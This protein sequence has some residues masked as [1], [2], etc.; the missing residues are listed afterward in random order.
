MSL[1]REIA[2]VARCVLAFLISLATELRIPYGR[3]LQAS[4]PLRHPITSPSSSTTTSKSLSSVSSV[5]CIAGELRLFKPGTCGRRPLR[6]GGVIEPHDCSVY[7]IPSVGDTAIPVV[8]LKA[9][10]QSG[11][12][13]PQCSC[14]TTRCDSLSCEKHGRPTLLPSMRNL[15][16]GL[17]CSR[18]FQRLSF[19]RSIWL[20][21]IVW[22]V[23]LVPMNLA[24][25]VHGPCGNRASPTQKR[26]AS[27]GVQPLSLGVGRWRSTRCTDNKSF[28]TSGEIMDLQSR[29]R[30]LEWLLLWTGGRISG[31]LLRGG[32]L[33]SDYEATRSTAVHAALGEIA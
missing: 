9:L 11:V 5:P 14:L 17:R 28:V 19:C 31:R 6:S 27:I 8:M 24:I 25:S 16:V 4:L 33:R 1:S 3:F 30:N 13:K 15:A 18:G 2:L 23:V 29:R 10:V 32:H 12:G 22:R 20:W 7:T 26:C 21:V